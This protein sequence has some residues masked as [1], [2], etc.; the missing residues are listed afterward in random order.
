VR[1]GRAEFERLPSGSK[2]VLQ[3]L[4]DANVRMSAQDLARYDQPIT[5]PAQAECVKT[6]M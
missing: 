6:F 1:P 2:Q 4:H 5:N 3:V